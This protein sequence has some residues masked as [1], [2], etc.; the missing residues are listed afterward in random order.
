[1]IL[2]HSPKIKHI[3]SNLVQAFVLGMLLNSASAKEE[4]E[5][6]VTTGLVVSSHDGDTIK[7]KTPDRGI[8]TIRFSGADAPETGQA[9]WKASRGALRA[10]VEAQPVTV[11]CYKKDR[12]ERDVCNVY[13]DQLDVGLELIRR[14]VAW[15]A[16]QYA[17]ELSELQ[18]KSYRQAEENARQQKLGLWVEPD[19]MAPWDCRRQ[20]RAGQKCR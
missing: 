3:V 18:R 20:R 5:R 1:M 10:I 4:F 7:L 16:Y 2:I 6:F 14:G 8:L 19:P 11:D 17:S 13:V 12:Y 15:H 9:Y